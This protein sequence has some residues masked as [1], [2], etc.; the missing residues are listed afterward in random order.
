MP[1][2]ND[3]HAP[4]RRT[5]E[6]IS[7]TAALRHFAMY[8]GPTQSQQHIK[9]VHWYVA[10]RL[11]LEGGF[12]PDELT[13]RPPFSVVKRRGR[14][15]LYYSPETA[16]GAEATLLGG[17]KTK[18]VDIVIDKPGVGPVV[19]VS[20]KGMTGA[21]RNLTN[22][23]EETIGECTNLH[24]R[25]PA[26]VFGYFF[27][28]RANRVSVDGVTTHI[29]RSQSSRP[30]DANDIALDEDDHPVEAI[31][32]F[33]AALGAL[34]GRDGIR[35]DPSRYEAIALAMVD[36][37]GGQAGRVLNSFPAS[38]ST[39]RLERFFG[40]LYR[41][42]D[43]RNVVNAPDLAARHRRIAWSVDSPALTVELPEHLDY[44]VRISG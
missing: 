12:H 25:Y 39:L 5:C 33:H 3:S 44:D 36:V 21:F 32:R 42:Y 19:A 30:L 11:V 35:S 4:R 20:C 16:T 14:N 2:P 37:Q 23:M 1:L 24:I 38:T 31:S 8:D 6:W 13:P 10:C 26:L 43:E 17:L 15:F 34:T 40:A 27:V 22:R 9:P 28:I 29:G 7:R 18:N 41:Q